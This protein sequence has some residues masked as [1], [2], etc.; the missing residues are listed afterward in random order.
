MAVSEPSEETTGV[1]GLTTWTAV[2]VVV[3]ACFM[4]W[5]TLLTL[6]TYAFS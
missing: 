5:L 2:Y 3:G 1:P 4:L 6:L